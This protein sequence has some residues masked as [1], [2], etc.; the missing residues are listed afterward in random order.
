MGARPGHT[1]LGQ[2][3]LTLMEGLLYMLASVMVTLAHLI[4][5]APWEASFAHLTGIIK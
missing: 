4:L 3:W 2:E 1:E 5:K